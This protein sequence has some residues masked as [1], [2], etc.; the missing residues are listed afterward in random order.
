MSLGYRFRGKK[1]TIGSWQAGI[2]S[3]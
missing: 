3:R 1:K 2:S